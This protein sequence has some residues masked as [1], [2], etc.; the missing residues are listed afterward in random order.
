MTIGATIFTPD[1]VCA[2]L[3]LTPCQLNYQRRQKNI[4]YLKLGREVRYTEKH[5]TDFLKRCEVPCEAS[6]PSINI[7]MDAPPIGSSNIMTDSERDAALRGALSARK[8]LRQTSSLPPSR[9]HE[10]NPSHSQQRN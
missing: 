6:Q 3:G 10:T 1:Q 2:Q 7:Q 5:I 4:G 9:S 8:T